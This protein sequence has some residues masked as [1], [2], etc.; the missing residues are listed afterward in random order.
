MSLAVVHQAHAGA[1]W[2]DST[3]STG[4]PKK[5]PTYYANSPAGFRPDPFG[6]GP[7]IDTGTPLRKFIDP[8]PVLCGPPGTPIPAITG[9]NG[10]AL[11]GKCIPVAN[12]DITTYPDADYYEIGVVEFSEYLHGDLPKPTRLRGYVQLNDPANPV[13]V[14]NGV[15]TSGN[16][17]YLGPIIAATK[18][19]PVRIKYVNLIPTGPNGD[20]FIPV[21]KTLMSSGMGPLDANGNPCDPGAPNASCATYTENR[22]EIHLHGGFT[23]WISDGTPHQWVVPAGE[24]TPF[25]KGAS[26]QVVPDMVDPGNGAGTL[27]Y[28]N[29]QSS[30]LMFYHDHVAGLTRLN[31][32]VGEVSGYL[33]A[34]KPSTGENLL[35]LP[36]DQIPL[37]I[38]DKTF[39]P[40][41][42]NQAVNPTAYAAASA[43]LPNPPGINQVSVI[44]GVGQDE[45]WDTTHWGQYG[46]L[47]FPHVYEF[48]QDP[49][50]FDATN[51]VGRWDWGPYFWPVFPADLPLPD[52]S[53][54]NASTTPEAFNDTP[55]INGAAYPVLTVDPK[56]YRFRILNGANDRF[57]NLGFY[58]AGK[59][60]QSCSVTSGGAGYDPATTTLAFTGGHDPAIPNAMTP[61]GTVTVVGGA[62]TAVNLTT[63]GSAYTTAPTLAFTSATG[64]GAVATCTLSGATEMVMVPFDSSTTF[65]STG[66]LTGT[67]WGTP[68][69]R[70]GGVPSP[71]TA[72]P[73]II[74][75]G[76]E[77]GMLPAPV[78]IPSTPLNYEYNKRS[79]TV[80]N[81]LEKG[82]FLGAA[83]RA[84]IIVDFSQFAG[85]TLIL[86][87]DSPAPVPAGD[88]RIDYYT[89]NPDMSSSG[90]TVTTQPGVGPNT[91]TIMQIQ[92]NNVAAAA[93]YNVAAL[94]AAFPAA[95]S[96]T[97]D[98]PVVPETVYNP[99]FNQTWTDTYARI[100]TGAVYLG[101]YQGLTF[102]TPENITYT[103]APVCTTPATC[104][105]ALPGSRNQTATAGTTVTAYLESKAIQELF[106]PRGRMNATQGTELLFTT[107]NTQTTIPLG[108][109]DPATETIAD[110]ETQF[111]KITHNGVDTHPVH[112][113]LVN[114]QLINRV[115]WDG[116]VKMPDANEVGWK[117]TVR[118]NPLEDVIVA[119]RAK[120]PPLPFGV[121]NSSRSLDPSQALGST[122]GFNQIDPYTG[123]PAVVS[124]V[125]ANFGWEYVWHCHILGHEENDFMRPFVFLYTAVVPDAPTNLTTTTPSF[126]NTP[127]NITINWVDPTP[128]AAPT[129]MSNPKNEIGFSIERCAGLNCSNF[130][131]VGT[132]LANATSYTETALGSD[133]YSYVV[134]AYN[135]AGES[136]SSNI[137]N[138]VSNAVIDGICGTSNGLNFS[139]IP[140][141]GLCA[142]GTSSAVVQNG[143]ILTW[144]CSGINST[145]NGSCTAYIPVYTVT[146]VPGT[147]GTI[148]GTTPQ[149]VIYNLG[150]T[151]VTAVPNTGYHLVNWTE[152]ATVF[153][154]A[155]ALSLFNVVANHTITANFAIDTFVL[156]YVAGAGGI[157]TGTTPQTI[158]YFANAT[159]VTA[160]AN[161]GY[162]F[163]NWTDENGVVVSV[164]PDLTVL[165]VTAAHT[166]TAN[167]VGSYTATLGRCITGPTVVAAGSLPTYTFATT[168]FNVAAQVN[169]VPIT[170]TNGSYTFSTGV[171]INPVITATF[172]PN[173]AVTAN[174]LK[175]STQPVGGTG[176]PSLQSAYA[177]AATGNTIQLKAA[178][179]ASP[180]GALTT[181]RN[182]TVTLQ[183]GYDNAYTASCGTTN[184]QGGLTIAT[185]TVIVDNL[186]IQ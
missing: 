53:Y 28:T 29:A 83:E 134:K 163:V 94:A 26:F 65:P 159:T 66:G 77:G 74:Q 31:V 63:F 20:L 76:T 32:Y 71:L 132:A 154:T 126:A 100:F 135:A 36:V 181:N 67:G 177:A 103:K 33:V 72:G 123:V 102:V 153:G 10:T 52:G 8:L 96:G 64:A 13:T 119:I 130:A 151:T 115:G 21:D 147:N 157:L 50:S 84:D 11:A 99:A 166:Y 40:K 82:L 19:R 125:T 70:V 140:T 78:V 161:V 105:A 169:G 7:A 58:V 152:G 46:D 6:I 131:P 90:G 85:K 60:V 137:V 48:N 112:F 116:T 185:G 111:W 124:N 106:D 61:T 180:A 118:M 146:F 55:V 120:A 5:V 184:A 158:N 139:A 142:S 136:A 138:V 141:T 95:Y 145:V 39:V 30:R 168:G 176:Y 59:T 183:G 69:A 16:P 45:K 101:G 88:P 162:L 167:F 110:G 1:G 18:D 186:V 155:P 4:A 79:V 127:N 38:Q 47:W 87:N 49:N 117:E 129:T 9:G 175:L 44:N 92:V 144:G 93:P 56:A 35:P 89:G 68:D 25:L 165:G 57:F 156:N 42:I 12:P 24:N 23:P 51:P 54:G 148:Q 109:I 2:G 171:T 17:R 43:L 91:R 179:L 41:D 178:S 133:R 97:Q 98:L 107:A 149:S 160:T 182:I 128:V 73:D 122:M 75:I 104:L 108:Y 172:T 3:F 22:A 15:V 34:D 37:I 170:L 80:L 62:I 86:Y 114:V 143:T 121:P 81:V 113:H 164:T 150:A 27:Y 173:P 14:V 174:Y